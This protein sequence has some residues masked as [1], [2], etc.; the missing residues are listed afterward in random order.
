MR[1]AAPTAGLSPQLIKHFAIATVSV[2]ALLALFATDADWGAQAQLDEVEARNRLAA[3]EAEKL[4][5]KKVLAK[6]KIKKRSGS[7]MTMDDGGGMGSGG[8]GGGGGSF[9]PEPPARHAGM[10]QAGGPP[11]TE[12]GRAAAGPGRERSK[13]P[14]P[15]AKRAPTEEE[16]EA[17]LEASRQRSGSSSSDD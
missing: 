4:G 9:D 7:S 5:A 10:P 6:L 16:L 12:F 13:Q 15:D 17:M 11:Q 2:T 8:G 14:R 3:A 1:R